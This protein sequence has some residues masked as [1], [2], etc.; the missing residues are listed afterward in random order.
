MPKFHCRQCG[1]CCKQNWEIILD[2]EEDIFRWIEEKRYDILK[3]VVLNPKYQ[4]DPDRFDQTPQW[5]LDT[6][7]PLFGDTASKCPFLMDSDCRVPSRCLIHDSRPK[8]CR[9]FPYDGDHK[10]RLDIL[11]LCEGAIFYHSTIAEQEG[12]SFIEY[13]ER[14]NRL[15]PP[16]FLPPGP[17]SNELKEI[18][19]KY[20]KRELKISFMS[21]EGTQIAARALEDTKKKAIPGGL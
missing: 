9:R 5:I 3:K 8:V 7:H 2:L 17:F 11:D 16:Q 18:A 19:S 4:I 6:G 21:P 14:E 1:K 13:V 10:V 12:L 15:F 20:G